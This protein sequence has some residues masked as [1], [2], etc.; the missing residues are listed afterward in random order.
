MKARTSAQISISNQ[1]AALHR[2]HHRFAKNKEAVRPN[3][4][5]ALTER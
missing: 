3:G 1:T 2:Q 5:A 4:R